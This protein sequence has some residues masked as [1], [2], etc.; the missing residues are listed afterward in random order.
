VQGDGLERFKQL[1]GKRVMICPNHSFRHDPEVMFALSCFAG[2]QFNFVAAREVFDYNKGFNGIMLQ[3]MGVYS[4]V[5]GAADRESFKTTKNILVAGKKKLVLFPEGE[6]SWQNE[7]LLPLETG[8]VQLSYWALD[9]LHKTSPDEPL[10]ILPV[11]LKYTYRK[12][13]SAQ[14]EKTIERLERE[15]GVDSQGETSLYQRVR[16]CAMKVLGT[17]EQQ[18]NCKPAPDA[19]LNDRM[20]AVKEAALKSLAEVLDVDLPPLKSTYLDWVRILRN[21]MDDYIY[22]D[23]KDMSDYERKIHDEREG[24]IRGYYR[25][26]DRVVGFIA[27]YDGY[28]SPPA[29]QERIANVVEMLEGEVFGEKSVKGPRLVTIQIGQPI[30]LNERYDEYKKSKKTVVEAITGDLSK[31]IHGML[32]NLENSREHVYVT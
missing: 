19:T 4:V 8:A 15:L 30:N 16:A 31:Q 28:L 29:T 12:N 11:A 14:L 18:Y 3:K 9:E 17:L 23:T 25:D 24:K 10:Y 21:V 26:L 5:R 13:I 7:N 27:L 1:K 2:E 32:E 20:I 22:G 6:I